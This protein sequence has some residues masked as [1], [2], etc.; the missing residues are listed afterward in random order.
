MKEKPTYETLEKRVEE[1]ETKLALYEET[2]QWDI[3]EFLVNEW[4]KNGP[5]GIRDNKELVNE[6][7]LTEAEAFEALKQLAVLGITSN[8]S[9]G[10]ATYLTPEGYD[11]AKTGDRKTP[12][13]KQLKSK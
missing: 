1:L 13:A 12:L 10:F 6:L 9:M 4:D 11:I 2:I 3:I 5:P 8:D 7:K